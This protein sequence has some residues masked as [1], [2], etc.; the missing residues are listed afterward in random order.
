MLIKG[1][2]FDHRPG[3][4]IKSVS[5]AMK[6]SFLEGLKDFLSGFLFGGLISGARVE[7]GRLED[8]FRLLTLGEVMGI[9][10]MGNYYTL[11]FLPFQVQG[12]SAWQ[13]RMIKPKDLLDLIKE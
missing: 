9:P 7:K 4:V 6:Q 1:Y 2:P 10:F 5:A 13:K 12:F 8:L 3:G 11:R